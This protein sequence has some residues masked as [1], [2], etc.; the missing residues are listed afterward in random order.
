MVIGRCYTSST[1]GH[2]TRANEYANVF[3]SNLTAIVQRVSYPVLA[4]IQDDKER[5]VQGYR[6][7][8]K[9]TMF[10]TAVC[11]ISLGAVSEPLIYTLIGTKW[12]EAATY[13]PFI[14]VSMSLYPLHA[15]NLNILQVLGRSDIFLY[16]EF[17]KKVVGLIPIVIGIFYGIYYMLLISIFTGI[18]GLYLNTWDTGKALNYNFWKQI[19]DITP[20]YMT[21]FIIALSVYFLKYLPLPFYVILAI[22][23]I[24][25][26]ITGLV[27]SELL[28]L[29]EY[30]ELKSILIKLIKNKL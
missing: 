18:I 13:L 15:I 28:K 5:M 27:V 9:V 11:M 7:I 3:S 2:Y 12:H 10:V 1:L 21:A 29:G 25:G 16:L 22:Q 8:I 14:C 6:K 23:I 24:V 20:S 19:K 26:F 4:E 17:I 30:M